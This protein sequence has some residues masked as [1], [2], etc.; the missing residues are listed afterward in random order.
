MMAIVELVD[1]RRLSKEQSDEFHVREANGHRAAC[2]LIKPVKIESLPRRTARISIRSPSSE[3]IANL[4]FQ[5]IH[6]LPIELMCTI[7]F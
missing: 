3:P 7:M 5:M 4:R 2:L 1:P 6:G